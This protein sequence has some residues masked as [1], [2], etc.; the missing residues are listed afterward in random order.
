[1]KEIILKVLKTIPKSVMVWPEPDSELP[2]E[3]KKH[4]DFAAVNCQDFVEGRPGKTWW[5][6]SRYLRLWFRKVRST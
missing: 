5:I 6:G 3:D 1:M 2:N 4:A